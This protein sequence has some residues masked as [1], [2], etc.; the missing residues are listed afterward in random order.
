MKKIAILL[1]ALSILSC[2]DEPKN[3]ALISGTLTNSKAKK[4]TISKGDDTI[5]M[6]VKEDGSFGDTLKLDKPG[7]YNL[8]LGGIPQS[9]FIDQGDALHINAETKNDKL[10]LS[11][12]GEGAIENNY[13]INKIGVI[14]FSD[15]GASELFSKNEE[16]FKVAVENFKNGNIKALDALANIDEKFKDLEQKNLNYETLTLY[17]DY[18]N[19]HRYFAKDRSF[20]VSEDFLPEALTNMQFDD[21]D[22]YENSEVYKKLAINSSIDAVFSELNNLTDA[23]PENIKQLA[24]L[25]IPALK[26]DVIDFVGTMLISP[27]N[28]K[29]EE[30]YTFF[31]ANTTSEKVQ[32]KLTATFE[33]N[34]NLQKGMPSP[35]FVDYENNAGGT[36]SLDDLKGK[37]VYVDVWA[38]WCGPCIAEIPSLKEIEKA[39]HDENIEFVSA[40]IDTPVAYNKWKSMIVDKELGG[41]QLLADNAWQS[42]FV[43]DYGI[44]GIPR[45]ILIDP[46]GNIVSADAPR[47]SDDALKALFDSE[48]GSK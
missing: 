16:D 35:K 10:E 42:Q 28:D 7:F 38:T 8:T 6:Q 3:Y 48:L 45:F 12:E 21:V 15:A 33:K 37:Y 13:I 19:G 17:N 5:E 46:N 47:P 32:E 36:M 1:I 25:K 14:G 34:K 2:K 9:I 29:M 27:G 26:N 31:S 44:D 23:T 40:S 43:Q 22:S 39:Y 41:T 30:L 11:F 20:K 24:D 18:E 4:V